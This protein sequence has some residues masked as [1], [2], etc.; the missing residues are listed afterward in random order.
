MR[1]RTALYGVPGT[2]TRIAVTDAAQ[3]FADAVRVQNG[4]PAGL[5][6]VTV[7]EENMRYA[8]GVDPTQGANPVGHIHYPGDEIEL[9]GGQVI[10]NFRFI[11]E[12]NMTDSFLMVTAYFEVGTA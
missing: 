12:V 5:V 8:Y 9:K 2:T 3:Q 4:T 6:I 7:E 11:N 1:P 10:R